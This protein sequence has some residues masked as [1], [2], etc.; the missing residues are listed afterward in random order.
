M[1]PAPVTQ[2]FLGRLAANPNFRAWDDVLE[3]CG[4]RLDATQGSDRRWKHSE[5]LEAFQSELPHQRVVSVWFDQEYESVQEDTRHLLERA[6]AGPV[7]SSGDRFG[8]TW[9]LP[10]GHVL[11]LVVKKGDRSRVG[12]ALFVIRG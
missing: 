8:S 10:N 4:F 2:A 11:R 5:G 12:L 3:T 7:T 9:I 1:I 6:N